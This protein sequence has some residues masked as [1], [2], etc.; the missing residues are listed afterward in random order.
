MSLAYIQV[1][2]EQA[3][4]EQQLFQER[5]AIRAKHEE[6]VKVAQAKSVSP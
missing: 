1:K 4:A 3:E 5:C 2:Q 6:K